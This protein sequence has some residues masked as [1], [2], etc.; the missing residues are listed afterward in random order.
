[1]ADERAVLGASVDRLR[2]LVEPLSP[3]Q[4][5]QQAYPSE[6]SVAQVLGHLGSGAVIAGHR[7]DQALGGPEI[8][9]QPIWDEWN[10]KD[11]DAMVVDGL[12]A[13]AAFLHRLDALTTDERASF[14][15]PLG[16]M[17]L[18]DDA[19]IGFRV[20]EHVLHTWDV[21][22]AFYPAAVLPAGARTIVLRVVPMIA[23]FAG[24][25]TGSI[26]TLEVATTGPHDR[27]SV[28]AR[29]RRRQP[30]RG[31]WTGRR[32]AAGGGPRASGVR[33]LGPGPHAVLR[34]RR[35]RSG[36]ASAGLSR[37][38]RPRQALIAVP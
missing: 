34:G 19:Y 8:D 12:A 9:A 20:N 13:D 28:Q 17:E 36:G 3:E 25:A 5:R 10:A 1:M 35:G 30:V 18:D 26:R 2:D 14:V 33:A 7:V 15:V 32:G 29:R 38:L 22:V 31:P 16:P 4:R 37:G 24:K 11:P 23:G 6:W 21:E 27:Y